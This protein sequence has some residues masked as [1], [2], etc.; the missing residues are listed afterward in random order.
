MALET[1]PELPEISPVSDANTVKSDAQAHLLAAAY[2]DSSFAPPSRSAE[3]S[4]KGIQVAGPVPA[5]LMLEL[6]RLNAESTDGGDAQ[7]HLVGAGDNLKSFSPRRLAAIA[8]SDVN[9]SAPGNTVPLDARFAPG[10]RVPDHVQCASTVSDWLI[11]S[12]VI[13]PRDFQIRVKDMNRLL[14]AKFGAPERLSGNL[15]LSDFPKGSIGFI[16]GVGNSA[17]GNHIALFERRGDSV[18][19]VH[20]KNGTVV[21]EDIK[22]KFFS[23]SGRPRYSDMRIFRLK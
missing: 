1:A 9:T 2:D 3:D 14:A 20:N 19:I 6:P 12:G 16:T 11:E 18:S 15:D 5:G 21:R 10:Y 7:V 17:G 13:S 4:S 8:N 22:D 23:S